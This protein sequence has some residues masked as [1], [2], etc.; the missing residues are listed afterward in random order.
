M[1]KMFPMP[2]IQGGTIYDNWIA[3][4]SKPVSNDQFDIKIDHR[5]NE[6]NL[7]SAKYSQEWSN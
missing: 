5:F 3:S 2:N 7:M 6:N 4:G 1:M